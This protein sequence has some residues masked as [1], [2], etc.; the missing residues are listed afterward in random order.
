[1]NKENTKNVVRRFSFKNPFRKIVKLL[2]ILF[3]IAA[4]FYGLIW[5]PGEI[6]KVSLINAQINQENATIEGLK[7]SRNCDFFA[8]QDLI[9]AEEVAKKENKQ[10]TQEQRKTHYLNV[11]YNCLFLEGRYTAP[12]LTEEQKKEIQEGQEI[13]EKKTQ[14]VQENQEEQ[15]E[16]ITIE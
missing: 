7:I 1:M 11:L 15:Q 14:E 6:Y 8:R 10:V 12:E 16:E 2:L 9:K 3:T 5:I 4:V 13:Q